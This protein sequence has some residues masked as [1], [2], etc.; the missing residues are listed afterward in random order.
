MKYSILIT[1]LL[2]TFFLAAQFVGLSVI[3]R[4]IDYERSEPPGKLDRKVEWRPLPYKIE[5]PKLKEKTSFIY[6]ILAILLATALVFLIIKF[7]K[8]YLWKVWFFLAVVVCLSVAL[9]AFMPQYIAVIL[10]LILGVYKIARPN[11]LVHNITELLIYGGLAA[12]FV[13]VL[14]IFSASMLLIAIS[15]YDAIAVWKSKHMIKLARFQA[16]QRIFA[17]LFLP[18]K[19]AMPAP[20]APSA[21]PKKRAK[22]KPKIRTAILGGGDIGFPLLFA[23]TILKYFGFAKAVIPTIFVTAALAMLFFL[24][25]KERFYPAMPFLSA[26]CF[27]G[28][29]V[30]ML[31]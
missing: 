20:Q 22:V 13:P 6:I 28:L 9:S 16:K 31:L 10:S 19:A 15:V 11:I 23:G 30:V 21:L 27:L 17:G 1:C 5:R 8:P 14:S 4:Y 24:G 29:L 7:G 26:G 2:L 3:S 25:K 12:I 18:Y